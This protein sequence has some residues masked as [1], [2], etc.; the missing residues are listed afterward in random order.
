VSF[1]VGVNAA[2]P[3]WEWIGNAKAGV[4]V[5]FGKTA[6]LFLSA[7][8]TSIERIANVTKLKSD[9]ITIAMEH[10]MPI[11]QSVVVE[12]QLAKQVEVMA[13]QGG[14]GEYKATT[15]LNVAVP[16]AEGAV[17]S[18]AGNLSVSTQT[19]STTTQDFPNQSIVSGYRVVTL[20]RKGCFGSGMSAWKTW[21][22]RRMTTVKTVETTS[23]NFLR[24]RAR[25]DCRSLRS[26][27][28]PPFGRVGQSRCC[29]P[30]CGGDGRP[31]AAAPT[32]WEYE[33]AF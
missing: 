17:G 29:R 15:S 8:N 19:G 25:P 33:Q 7:S 18:L 1:Q 24:L 30:H 2:V 21:S 27:R 20:V 10:G 26:D 13:S 22:E 12:R 16:G 31:A 3:G 11:G 5:S 23:S 6:A 14:T 4:S 9:L 32:S 28:S